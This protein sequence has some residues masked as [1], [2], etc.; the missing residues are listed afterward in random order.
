MQKRSERYAGIHFGIHA[1][2][3]GGYTRSMEFKRT[4]NINVRLNVYY[5][6]AGAKEA[7]EV[8]RTCGE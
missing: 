6:Q 5:T 7:Q 2:Y 4:T 3:A 8:T 1:Q